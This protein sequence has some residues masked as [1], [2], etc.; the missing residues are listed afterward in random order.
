LL[1]TFFGLFTYLAIISEDGY[2]DT[3]LFAVPGLLIIAGIFLKRKHFCFFTVITLSLIATLVGLETFQIHQTRFSSFVSP[4][5]GIDI[6]IITA[7]IAVSV[8]ILTDNLMNSLR[9]ARENERALQESEEKY[10]NLVKYAPTG[11]YEFDMEKL[12]FTGVNDVM[13]EYTGY[14]ED[15]FLA[16]NPFDILDDQSKVTMTKMVEKVLSEKP[17]ELPGEF[18]LKGKNQRE[19]WVLINSKFFYDN[20]VPKRAMAVV[21]DL[22][23][24]RH[25]EEKRRRLEAQL[26][27]ACK[28]EAIGTLAGGIAHDFNNILSGIFGYSQMAKTNLNHPDKADKNIDQ[29]IKGARRAADLV[30]QILTF[31]R[32]TEYQKKPFRIYLEINE[33]LKLLRSTIP[34]TIEI[35]KKLNTRSMISADPTKIHQLIMNLCTNAYHAMKEAGG[36]LTVALSDVQIHESKQAKSKKI[37]PGKYVKLEVSDTGYGMA[38][39][40]LERVFDPY[41]TTKEAGEGT[42]FGLAIV[43]AVVDEHEGFL[44]VKSTPGKGTDFYIYFP[45]VTKDVEPDCKD[46]TKSIS[47]EGNEQIL[48]VDDEEAIRKIAKANFKRYGYGVVLRKNGIEALEEF[49]KNYNQ[50]D[51]IITDMNMPGM[52][53][54]VFLT[55]VKKINSDIPII[56]CTG[57]SDTMTEEKASSMGI[58]AY[59]MK[60][61]QMDDLCLKI[62]QVFDREE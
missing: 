9:Y 34:S 11:I 50:F 43:Q 5:D 42:G 61:V 6:I 20:G 54:D 33:A 8:R 10:R 18:Q 62:R 40:A 46:D 51:I 17:R 36:S 60:P 27:Q 23:D 15:E 38:E 35:V 37:V 14:T 30:Q 55:E 44:E 7:L 22:T 41:Y 16:L 3:V 26:Y 31:S 4:Y 28:M 45:I 25:S 47:L 52:A 56:L 58:S 24:I 2:H 21:H 29:V 53:G 59:M 1:S 32:Q 12:K 57:F 19:F 48:F 39:T 13:C 49:K